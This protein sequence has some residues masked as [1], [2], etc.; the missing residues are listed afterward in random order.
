MI[1]DAPNDAD[2]LAAIRELETAESKLVVL[3]LVRAGGATVD[4]LKRALGMQLLTLFGV[5]RTLRDRGIVGRRDDV[6]TCRV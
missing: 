1:R 5:L 6:W 4:E 2:E 3:Y